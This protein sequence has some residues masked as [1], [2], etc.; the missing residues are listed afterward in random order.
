MNKRKLTFRV[1][2]ILTAGYLLSV[3]ILF[4]A[5]RT[6]LEGSTL[7][8]VKAVHGTSYIASRGGPNEHAFYARVYGNTAVG[9]MF[10]LASLVITWVLA[11]PRSA[12]HRDTLIEMMNTPTKATGPRVPTWLFWAVITCFTGW[13]LYAATH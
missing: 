2:V 6:W 7:I 5:W 9:V 8:Y 11:F 3:G 1:C 13:L 10:L 4:D 12:A